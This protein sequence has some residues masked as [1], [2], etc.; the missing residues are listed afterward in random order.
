MGW[1]KKKK[2]K[3]NTI[4]YILVYTWYIYDECQVSTPQS[5]TRYQVLLQLYEHL[6]AINNY[7]VLSA[8]IIHELVL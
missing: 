6:S 1:K 3:K 8:I 2:K 7:Q 4:V 5:S